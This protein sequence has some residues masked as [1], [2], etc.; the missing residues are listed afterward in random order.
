MDSNFIKE[1]AFRYIVE[2]V[3]SWS[4]GMEEDERGWQCPSKQAGEDKTE[5]HI[6]SYLRG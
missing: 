4:M 5:K 3:S 1:A 6:T 2:R